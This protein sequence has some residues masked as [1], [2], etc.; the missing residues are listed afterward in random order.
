[1]SKLPN[2]LPSDKLPWA[3]AFELADVEIS[4]IK[5][6]YQGH[7][8][9]SQLEL[10]HRCF[11]GAWSETM[12]REHLDRHDAASAVL[13]DPVQDSVVLVEQLRIGLLNRADKTNP[14]MLEI[15]AGLID[16]EP[17]PEETIRREAIEEAG[18]VIETLIPIGRFYNSPGGFSELTYV[19]CGIIRLDGSPLKNQP[20]PDEDIKIHVIQWKALQ[21]LMQSDWVTSASSYIALQWLAQHREGLIAEYAT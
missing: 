14:W 9:V 21:T 19:Y 4:A 3:P 2:K 20:E 15:V 16:Q 6:A 7:Y 17:S 1:M 5:P 13:Y 8:Q 10:K 18:C 12:I 11:N